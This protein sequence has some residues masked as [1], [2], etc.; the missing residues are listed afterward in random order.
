[1]YKMFAI[2]IS[3]I[4]NIGITPNNNE[5]LILG[6]CLGMFMLGCAIDQIITLIQNQNKG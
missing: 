6:I 5:I 3:M 1:M 4:I 2:L